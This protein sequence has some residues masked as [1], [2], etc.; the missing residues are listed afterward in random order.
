MKIKAKIVAVVVTVILAIVLASSMY[1]LK[2]N[3]Y[4]LVKQFG[5]VVEVKKDAGLYFKKPFI[6]SVMR[7]PKDEQLYDL[8]SSDVITS[9]KKSMIADCSV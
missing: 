8:A 9:D 4:G 2:E 6:Q 1:T 7:Q 5:K 3:E